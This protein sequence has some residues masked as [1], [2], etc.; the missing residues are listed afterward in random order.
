MNTNCQATNL[1]FFEVVCSK[2]VIFRPTMQNRSEAC[3][4][5][6]MIVILIYY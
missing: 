2:N 4:V 5:P 6:E 1:F 3:I